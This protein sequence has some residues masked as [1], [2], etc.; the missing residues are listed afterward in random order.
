MKFILTLQR[1]CVI[2][3]LKPCFIKQN[4]TQKLVTTVF[5]QK[6][7]SN[8]ATAAKRKYIPRRSVLYVPGND[9]RKISKVTSL[10][11]DCV[12]LDCEDGV[13]A[14]RK[15]EARNTISQCLEKLGGCKGDVSVRVNAVGS[16]L[17]EEDLK[18]I[19]QSSCPP[20]T[21]VLP[22]VNT[23]EEMERFTKRLQENLPEEGIKDKINLITMVESAVGLMNLKDV[24][25]RATQLSRSEQLYDLEGVIF[26]SD[27]FCA[28]IGG[29]VLTKKMELY[30]V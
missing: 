1:S 10:D 28:D 12:V 5:A 7:Y 4:Q 15:T 22:K 13:A 25:L 19:F 23:P 27:D 9:E 8:Q 3:V 30:E 2:D 20:K 29:E 18:V 26:G 17:M 14:N 11:V 6:F 24:F 21:L 16:G